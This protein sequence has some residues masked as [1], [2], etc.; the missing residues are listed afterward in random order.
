MPGKLTPARTKANKKW[1]DANKARKQYLNKRSVARNFIKKSATVADL[2]ELAL[3]IDARR[4]TLN[5]SN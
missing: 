1:D 4:D 5:T 3:L 2:D